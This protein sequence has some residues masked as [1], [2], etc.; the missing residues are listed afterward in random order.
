MKSTATRLARFLVP[1]V[2]AFC[3]LP[4]QAAAPTAVV[5][6]SGPGHAGIASAYP[7]ASDA[8]REILA[9]DGNPVASQSRDTALAAGIPGEP[10]GLVYMAKKFGKLPLSVSMAPAIKLARNG[11]PMYDRL[12]GQVTFKK[13][14]FLKSPDASSVWL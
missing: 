8:G 7:L 12:R 1:F 13:D 9:K 4:L 5:P 2:I 3:V 14:A 6:K 10:A 11:F